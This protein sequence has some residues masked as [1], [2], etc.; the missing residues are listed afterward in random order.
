M[1]HKWRL[2]LIPLSMALL[3][4]ADQPQPWKD[5][6]VPEWNEDDTKQI[7]TDSPW[8]KTV[9]PSMDT[10]ASN[11]RSRQGGGMGRG[12]GINL[13]GIILGMPGGM[14]RGG[15]GYPG[16]GGGYPGGGGGYPGGGGGYP[17]GGGGYPGGGGGYPG[18]STGYPGGQQGGSGANSQPPVL[19]LRWESAFPIREAELKSHDA[20]APTLDDDAHYAI[21]VYGVPSRMTNGNSRSA[22]DQLKN[23]AAIKRDGKKDLKPSSVEV[24][25]RDNGP[26]I[27]YLF[28][29]KTEITLKDARIEFDAKI[30][31][32]Q[33]TQSFYVDD[34]KY[35]DKL[36]L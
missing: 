22:T 25:E 18:D 36:E 14:G 1:T 26:V 10:S 32:L 17:G 6:K 2:S 7:L 16:G 28:P 31:R 12:G 8:A 20:N 15:G 11:G 34:M 35:Q 4:A 29:R 19:Q 13:G 27:V 5:K 21:A 24:L 9:T 33:F 3:T 30:G 23:L